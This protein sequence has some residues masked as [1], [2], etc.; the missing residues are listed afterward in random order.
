[1]KCYNCPKLAMYSVGPKGEE[2]PLCLDCYVKWVNAQVR[3]HEMLE[4]QMERA[5]ADMEMVSGVSLPRRQ[6][7]ERKTIIHTGEITLN[8]I[9]VSNGQVGV[10]NTGTVES[11]D[12]SLTVL[13]SEGS[14]E[15][16]QTVQKLSE[17]VIS[18]DEL[19][20][21][22]K[23]QILELLGTLSEEAIAPPEKRKSAVAKAVLTELSGALSG[24]AVLANAFQ[25][26]RPVLAQVFGI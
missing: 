12:S 18:S 4:R 19:S 11:L 26:A 13:N 9:N 21:A 23:N 15:I 25:K 7:P 17:G 20:N 10:L 8:N 5:L 16:A 3:Q 14:R 1:M 24:I 22:Q 6:L 2:V